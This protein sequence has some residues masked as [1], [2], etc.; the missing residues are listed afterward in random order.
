MI[1]KN[2]N[3]QT[4]DKPIYLWVYKQNKKAI[5]LYKRLGFKIINE[6]DTRYFMKHCL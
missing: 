3:C 1:I 2:Y 5:K 4:P 6:T